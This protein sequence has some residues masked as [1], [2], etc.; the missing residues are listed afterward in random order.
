MHYQSATSK[1][2]IG[3][4]R[5]IAHRKID[6]FLPT[7]MVKEALSQLKG[8]KDILLH[9]ISMIILMDLN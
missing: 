1:F 9:L 2:K 7:L 6:N 5:A 3:C 8:Q 4:A